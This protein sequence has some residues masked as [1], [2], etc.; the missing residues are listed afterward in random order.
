M[1][2]THTMR[3]KFDFVID[4]S[5]GEIEIPTDINSAVC[6]AVKALGI[7]DGYIRPGA[8]MDLI[9]VPPKRRKGEVLQQGRKKRVPAE[10]R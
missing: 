4:I 8:H 5:E 6:A 10:I 7:K 3:I 1:K 2:T 9:R